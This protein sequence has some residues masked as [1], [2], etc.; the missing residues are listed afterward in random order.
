MIRLLLLN[1]FAGTAAGAVLILLSFI[2]PRLGLTGDRHREADPG[3]IGSMPRRQ[4]NVLST[5]I[6]LLIFGLLGMGY[7]AILV[8]SGLINYSVV[9]LLA[10]AVLATLVFGGIVFP[11]EGSG[12]FGWRE[13]HWI[14]A[15]LFVMNCAWAFLYWMVVVAI[16]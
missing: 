1:A 11:L 4:A 15:D 2:L 5:A 13:D 14:A 10:Y 3:E 7:G 12:L 16:Q 6:H 8:S 9:P